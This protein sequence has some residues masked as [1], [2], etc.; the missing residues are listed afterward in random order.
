MA[1][2]GSSI[3]VATELAVVGEPRVGTLDNPTKSET[4]KLLDRRLILRGNDSGTC[5]GEPRRL[6]PRQIGIRDPKS[7]SSDA[8]WA[9]NP[10]M[11]DNSGL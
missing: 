7:V 1:V 4:E 2:L 6:T 10:V 11:G 5:R 9:P 8:P 3:S